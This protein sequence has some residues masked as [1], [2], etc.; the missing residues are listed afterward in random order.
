MSKSTNFCNEVLKTLPRGD[1]CCL[2]PPHL[3]PS[4][5]CN[6]EP[7]GEA[8]CHLHPHGTSPWASFYPS[9]E[10]NLVTSMF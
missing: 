9:T 4:H 1:V 8:G 5:L 2:P 10:K 7:T 6:N 3:P